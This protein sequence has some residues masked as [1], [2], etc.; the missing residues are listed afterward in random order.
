MRQRLPDVCPGRS[1]WSL[2]VRMTPS[3]RSGVAIAWAIGVWTGLTAVVMIF[4]LLFSQS[5]G[6]EH[7]IPIPL[8]LIPLCFG[9][10]PAIVVGIWKYRSR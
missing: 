2:G 9:W 4:E 7:G 1:V 6:P 5:D 10:I 8:F 3:K